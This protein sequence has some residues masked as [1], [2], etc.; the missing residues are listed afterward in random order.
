MRSLLSGFV[1]KLSLGALLLTPL[2]I[3]S[4]SP[5]KKTTES[6]EE[7]QKT[8]CLAQNPSL[9]KTYDFREYPAELGP[10][11]AAPKKGLVGFLQ[12]VLPFL[13]SPE[14]KYAINDV[15]FLQGT[16]GLK[17]PIG[18]SK[19]SYQIRMNAK[20]KLKAL[21]LQGEENW[22]EWLKQ[23]PNAGSEEKNKAESRI[24]YQGLGATKLTKFDWR[25]QGLDVGE[26]GFQGWKCRSCWAFASVDAAQASRQLAAMRAGKKDFNE[27]NRPNVRQLMS[28]MYPKS[29]DYCLETPQ[30]WDT[31]TYMID[32]GLPLG[33]FSKYDGDED[34]FDWECDPKTRVKALTWDYVSGQPQE[35]A[36][37]EALKE[38]L[39][40]YGPLVTA[41][42]MDTCLPLY[43]GKIFNEAQNSKETDEAFHDVLIIGW[44]DT[45]GAWLIKNSYGAEWGDKGFGWIKYE[46]NNIGRW[47]AFIVPDPKEE[48]RIAKESNQDN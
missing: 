19:S 11:G 3:F 38:A 34:K 47:A 48:E 12:K 15:K 24:R 29:K 37:K 26:V 27:K 23:N 17:A 39:I 25:E 30:F 35:I 44:D 7:K 36:S 20:D 9:S 13:R 42:N 10:V 43:G 14:E 8:A 18:E 5:T 46:S 41:M 32:E 28:C 21:Q 16:W 33:G 45:K 2:A 4:Q 1:V 40:V 6:W 31:F 22:E